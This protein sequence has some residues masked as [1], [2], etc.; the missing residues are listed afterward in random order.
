MMFPSSSQQLIGY[1][2]VKE[3]PGK[4]TE[5]LEMLGMDFSD[6]DNYK[7]HRNIKDGGT[8]AMTFV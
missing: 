2:K 1:L 7:A 5:T 3:T 4:I 8:L 6:F